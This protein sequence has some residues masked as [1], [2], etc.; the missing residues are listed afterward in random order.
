MGA[1]QSVIV[2]LSFVVE[3][4]FGAARSFFLTAEG[5]GFGFIF[6]SWPSSRSS[7]PP[8]AGSFIS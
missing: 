7:S 3:L 6:A 4:Y 8:F 1:F 5:I 2:Y